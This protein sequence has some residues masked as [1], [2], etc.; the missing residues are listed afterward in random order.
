MI[1]RLA[2]AEPPYVASTAV[3][4]RL[5]L[6]TYKVQLSQP[7]VDTATHGV[8]DKTAVAIPKLCKP[9]LL[10]DHTSISIVGDGY[11][12]FSV[13]FQA[14]YGNEGQHLLL[15]LLTALEI[16]EQSAHYS[17]PRRD[18]DKMTDYDDLLLSTCQRGAYMSLC[19]LYP[20][21]CVIGRPI[22]SHHPSSGDILSSWMSRVCGRNVKNQ[23]TDIKVMWSSVQ[24]PTKASLF[25]PNYFVLLK[26]KPHSTDTNIITIDEEWPTLNSRTIIT[27]TPKKVRGKRKV[28]IQVAPQLK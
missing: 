8:V 27:G 24:V 4:E 20:L 16:A 22:M 15:R 13:I 23:P 12:L 1:D 10:D 9:G 7:V 11:C 19:H 18:S 6:K 14:M 3:Q 5:L 28:P 25:N 21:S 17:T 2:S 26:S